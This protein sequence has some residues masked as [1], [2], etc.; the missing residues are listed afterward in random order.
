MK[1]K[2]AFI[3][4]ILLSLVI[5]V[6]S[7]P[8][9]AD[10]QEV[11][12]QEHK[13]NYIFVIGRWLENLETFPSYALE[14]QQS[15]GDSAYIPDQMDVFVEQNAAT[16]RS[17]LRKLKSDRPIPV[18]SISN[19][20]SGA[21]SS[22]VLTTGEMISLVSMHNAYEKEH[23]EWERESKAPPLA[24]APCTGLICIKLPVLLLIEPMKP[25]PMF[26]RPSKDNGYQRR[27][28]SVAEGVHAADLLAEARFPELRLGFRLGEVTFSSR[29]TKRERLDL[30]QAVVDQHSVIDPINRYLN[31]LETEIDDAT[32]VYKK[33][34]ESESRR[35]RPFEKS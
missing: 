26:S 19:F 25:Q 27:E 18:T 10:D 14:L 9:L 28:L 33:L 21:N 30:R 8:T 22:G 32:E 12:T 13:D 29:E 15:L 6:T 1:N 11:M 4:A 3:S 2:N 31:S 20:V 16:L 5:L 7:F 23:A 24:P 34:A 17:V 35:L